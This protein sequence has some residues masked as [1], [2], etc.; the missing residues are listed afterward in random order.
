MS[1]KVSN[2]TPYFD[3]FVKKKPFR[4]FKYYILIKVSNIFMY[5][6]IYIIYIHTLVSCTYFLFSKLRRNIGVEIY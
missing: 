3:T 1:F 5:I 6:Y 4:R 2:I